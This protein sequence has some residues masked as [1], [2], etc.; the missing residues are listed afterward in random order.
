MNSALPDSSLAVVIETPL[1]RMVARA[2]EDGL[3]SLGFLGDGDGA[4][5]GPAED[6]PA[7]AER[8][9][10]AAILARLK[11]ELG[12]YFAGLRT[13]FDIPLSPE[14]T[15]FQR[16]VWAQLATIPYG[17][18]ISYSEQA[19]ALGNP[20]S[21]R[22][23]ASANGANPIAILVPCHR[24]IGSDGSLTGYAGGLRRKRALLELEGALGADNPS[25]FPEHE[26]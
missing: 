7:G 22:A 15:P 1:G 10:A 14:G 18:T 26:K 24:V 9:A 11:A 4:D 17:A 21:V 6:F 5:D 13:G 23:S 19:A 2:G 16:S 20:K 25:L 3:R 12:E 8:N